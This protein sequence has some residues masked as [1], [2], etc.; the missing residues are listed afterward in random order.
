M[1]IGHG[2]D[3]IEIKRVSAIYQKFNNTFINKYFA[4]DKI[5]TITPKILSNNFA[6]KEAFSK[7]LGLG[8]R[9]PC[10]PKNISIQRDKMGKPEIYPK[11]ELN[12]YMKEKFG[13]F[14]IHVSLSDTNKHS[15]ASVI[16]EKT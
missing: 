12:E 10:Y 2:I 7:S 11:N 5:D 13:N 9:A 14:L 16:I 6:I 3:L 4:L 15:I 8:F 1:I